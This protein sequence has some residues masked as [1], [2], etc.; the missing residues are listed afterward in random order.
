M[1]LLT[2]DRRNGSSGPILYE[3]LS[4][5]DS[6]G[7]RREQRSLK[8]QAAVLSGNKSSRFSD[9][10]QNPSRSFG[11]HFFSS[12]FSV[13]ACSTWLSHNARG[14]RR[15]GAWVV[16]LSPLL[17]LDTLARSASARP[18]LTLEAQVKAVFLFNFAQ[19]TEWPAQAFENQ[20]APIV[21]GIVGIDPF[22][23]FLDETV[24]NELINGRRIRIERYHS[25]AQVKNW[26][27][28][29][30]GSIDPERLEQVLQSIKGK[31]VLSVSEHENALAQGEAIIRFVTKKSKIRF[32]INAQAARNA[33][34]V[35]SSKLLH[36][37]DEVIDSGRK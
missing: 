7:N 2:R 13:S 22:G 32:I 28:I 20:T 14:A 3:R 9:E 18:D 33:K 34:L 17:L 16:L 10:S 35:L 25:L 15:F 30:I 21:I 8:D 6:E 19:F 29:Y 24:Q 37:A 36:V 27:M 26:H 31:P 11:V 1:A 23:E 5:N 12:I 4:R